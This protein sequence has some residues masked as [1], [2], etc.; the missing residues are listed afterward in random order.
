MAVPVDL[1]RVD[2]DFK[3]AKKAPRAKRLSVFSSLA[4]RLTS[5][6]RR[7]VGECWIICFARAVMDGRKSRMRIDR[8]CRGMEVLALCLQFCAA[9]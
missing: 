8:V 2:R 1:V 4:A 3:H 9:P 6:L 5:H 7:G